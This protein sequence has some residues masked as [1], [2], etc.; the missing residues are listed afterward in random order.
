MHYHKYRDEIVYVSACQAIFTISGENYTAK[1]GDLMY[2]PALTLHRVVAVGNENL[3]MVSTF[4]PPFDG[5]DRIYVE[6]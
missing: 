6:N 3:Q 5:K 1:A 2:L 4:A